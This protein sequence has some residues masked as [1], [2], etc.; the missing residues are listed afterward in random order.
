M[1]KLNNKH[2]KK[3]RD[4]KNI[5]KWWK[6]LQGKH[7][8]AVLDSSLHPPAPAFSIAFNLLSEATDGGTT[9]NG[10]NISTN[11]SIIYNELKN[12]TETATFACGYQDITNTFK[13]MLCND[14]CSSTCCVSS[15]NCTKKATCET[16]CSDDPSPEFRETTLTQKMIDHMEETCIPQLTAWNRRYAVTIFIKSKKI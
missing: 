16:S 3:L 1:A 13:K 8:K 7:G 10:G 15:P 4:L 11:A 14:T 12:C 9:C 5:L 6:L 2:D